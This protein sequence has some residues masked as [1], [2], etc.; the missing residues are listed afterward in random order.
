VFLQSLLTKI[1][2]DILSAVVYMYVIFE[3]SVK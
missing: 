1:V 2:M 3:S